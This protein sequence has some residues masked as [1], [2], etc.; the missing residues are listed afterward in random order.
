M[1]TMGAGASVLHGKQRRLAIFCTE[2]HGFLVIRGEIAG[3]D[4]DVDMS[5]DTDELGDHYE[6]NYDG[7]FGDPN[8]ADWIPSM[9]TESDELFDAP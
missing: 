7:F 3:F 6:E 5:V 9:S 4:T 2:R 8:E 1:Q